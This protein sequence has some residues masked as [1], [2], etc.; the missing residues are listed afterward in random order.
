MRSSGSHGICRIKVM[1]AA[2]LAT[3]TENVIKTKLRND[4]AAI[5]MCENTEV[6]A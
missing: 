2:F 3:L 5:A 4:F 1:M 6:L